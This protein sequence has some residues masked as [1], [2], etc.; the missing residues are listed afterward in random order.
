MLN[1]GAAAVIS[2]Q[3]F[4]DGAEEQYGLWETRFL[5][6]LHIQKIKETILPGEVTGEQRAKECKLL[7]QVNKTQR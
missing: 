3:L 4:I 6:H 5:G 2:Q 1:T 7:C